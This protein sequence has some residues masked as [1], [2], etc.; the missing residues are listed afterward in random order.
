LET[1][2]TWTGTPFLCRAHRLNVFKEQELLDLT[3]LGNFIE[4]S[5][6]LVPRFHEKEMSDIE[7]Q[8]RDNIDNIWHQFK[9][10]FSEKQRLVINGK[11]CEPKEK[12]FD[13]SFLALAV[14]LV[15]YKENLD[16]VDQSFTLPQLKSTIT[17]YVKQKY[18][19][20]SS[21]L[22]RDLEQELPSP[23]LQWKG[24]SF[25]VISKDIEVMISGESGCW[26]R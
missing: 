3:M 22:A 7:K 15:K 24:A 12:L 23:L 21:P 14:T 11:T 19:H 10:T 6:F 13:P 20:L 9:K 8:E 16:G 25:T 4:L 26:T 18:P 2:P 1:D 5:R 17:R